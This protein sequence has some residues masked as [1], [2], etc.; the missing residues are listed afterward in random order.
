MLI[1]H[2]LTRTRQDGKRIVPVC[3]A[4][5]RHLARHDGFADITDPV[6][7]DILTWLTKVL[8]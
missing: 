5:A 6:R 7:N 3:P 4:V 1:E 8:A 2:A